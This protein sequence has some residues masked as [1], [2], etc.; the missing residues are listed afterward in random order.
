M[1]LATLLS[2]AALALTASAFLVPLEVT[3]KADVTAGSL[4]PGAKQQT[5][6]LDCPDC[7]IALQGA[8]AEFAGWNVVEDGNAQPSSS[9]ELTFT[10]ER[11]QVKL[12]DVR[13]FPPPLPRGLPIRAK[14][15]TSEK[16]LKVFEAGVP[17][18][19]S[20]E[21]RMGEPIVGANDEGVLKIHS[22]SVE[23]VGLA[24]RVV[25]ADTLRLLIAE[26]DDGEVCRPIR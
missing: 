25:R 2:S 18:S 19:T 23:I 8:T 4:L 13:I 14:Q 10:A 7:P 26:G 22:V 5:I 21:I 20:I 15:V 16:N 11:D 1:R 12:N 17:L 24:E 9:L 6:N 3:G